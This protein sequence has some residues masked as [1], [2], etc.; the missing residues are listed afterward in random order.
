M[1][2]LT[3]T[4]TIFLKRCSNFLRPF[5]KSIFA[6]NLFLGPFAIIERIRESEM[7]L[8]STHVHAV[9]ISSVILQVNI[10]VMSSNTSIFMLTLLH[11]IELE[12]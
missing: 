2:S 9:I 8:F 1:L 10:I 4:I 12:I 7:I 11:Q 6:R 3:S 5:W